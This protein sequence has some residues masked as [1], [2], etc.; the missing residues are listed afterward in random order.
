MKKIGRIIEGLFVF[1][2]FCLM[3]IAV[4]MI[5]VGTW[6]WAGSFIASAN[7]TVL[8]WVSIAVVALVGGTVGVIWY[9]CD[10]E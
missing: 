6:R 3:T 7:P 1:F 4:V 5:C 9:I 2:F 10:T 8:E